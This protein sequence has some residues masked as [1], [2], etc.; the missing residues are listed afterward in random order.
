ML[1][2]RHSEVAKVVDRWL[3]PNHCYLKA[4]GCD[5]DIYILRH[6]SER[7]RWELTMLEARHGDSPGVFRVRA[8]G[9]PPNLRTVLV[10]HTNPMERDAQ[11]LGLRVR[12]LNQQ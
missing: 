3:A 8:G 6:D 9:T 4:T 2:D 10:D 7:D 1:G 5:A 11:G 12:V